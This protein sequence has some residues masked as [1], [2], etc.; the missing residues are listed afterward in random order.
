MDNKALI[1]LGDGGLRR[2]VEDY[3]REK[4]IKNV[5]FPGFK[6]QRDIPAYYAASDIF[7]LPSGI[8]ETWGLAVNEAMCFNLPIVISDLAGC[9]KDLVK[10]GENGF[11]FK[12]GNI[13]ELAACLKKLVENAQLREKMGKRSF[14]TIKEWNYRSVTEGILEALG[15]CLKPP[16]DKIRL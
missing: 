10:H 14:E 5:Y 13:E 12:T 11:I 15:S 16:G 9:G 3:A 8:G 2:S 4:G 6:N 7:V 1:F